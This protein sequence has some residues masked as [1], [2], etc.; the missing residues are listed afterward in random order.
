[1]FSCLKQRLGQ[2]AQQIEIT[3]AHTRARAHAHEAPGV[4]AQLPVNVSLT[5]RA[6]IHPA[7]GEQSNG[8][9][10][11]PGGLAGGGMEGGEGT[12]QRGTR[13]ERRECARRTL[14]EMPLI[15]AAITA[16]RH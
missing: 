12:V 15:K 5:F 10:Q 16:A 9:D 2:V 14:K 13:E 8:P 6:E 7:A 11:T 1:M 4:L 3:N